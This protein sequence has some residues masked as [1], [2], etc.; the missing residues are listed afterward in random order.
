VSGSTLGSG[1][2]G[3]PGCD[4]LL[5]AGSGRGGAGFQLLPAGLQPG[6][7]VAMP[8]QS[9]GPRRAARRGPE[10][11]ILLGVRRF[12]LRQHPVDRLRDGAGGAVGIERGVGLCPI[13]RQPDQPGLAA[14]LQ[15][16]QEDARHPLR[17][18][19]TEPRDD[20]VVRHVVADD[21]PVARVA[22]AQP[23]DHP[24]R[25]DAVAVGVDQ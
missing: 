4:L 16:L 23:L 3:L 14:Q 15:H 20:R 1:S 6:Q 10:L 19:P 22:A 11:P 24:A 12:G 9:L 21:E 2:F 18:P 5:L 8:P 13:Q 7:T 25:P 17:M